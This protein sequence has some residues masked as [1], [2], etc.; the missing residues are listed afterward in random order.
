MT[1]QASAPATVSYE[2]LP[3]WRTAMSL[4]A[5][6]EK[7][8][9]DPPAWLPYVAERLPFEK[10][11]VRRDWNRFLSFCKAVALCRRTSVRAHEPINIAFADYCV[12]Y[13]ILEPVLAS[14]M[15]GLPTA[16]LAVSQAVAA[17]NK[18][19]KR[20]VTIHEVAEEL[21]WKDPLAYKHVKLAARRKLLNYEPGTREKNVKRLLAR[22]D[23]IDGF[24][25]SPI[26][27]FKDNPEIGPEARYIDPFT[28]AKKLIRRST[29]RRHK[30]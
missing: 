26:S 13:R 16:E 5:C 27:V 12:A 6:D 28:G 20:A 23:S 1:A 19:L 30:A 15:Q 18:R 9:L 29:R 11:S 24:L 14:T 21:S 10:V 7:D 4:L 17:L 3:V 25:P 8:F 2:D 22:A